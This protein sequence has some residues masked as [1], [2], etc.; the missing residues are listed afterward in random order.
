M[1]IRAIKMLVTLPFKAGLYTGLIA[2]GACAG[3]YGPWLWSTGMEAFAA[4]RTKADATFDPQVLVSPEKELDLI[5]K[6]RDRIAPD[7]ERAQCLRRQENAELDYLK[8]K[9]KLIEERVPRGDNETRS[10]GQILEDLANAIS[11]NSASAADR[12]LFEDLGGP[13]WALLRKRASALKAS[14]EELTA[15]NDRVLR[16][17]EQLDKKRQMTL[18]FVPE[19][20]KSQT[21]SPATDV[22]KPT[23]P[24]I[25]EM[26]TL[27]EQSHENLFK[28]LHALDAG[29]LDEASKEAPKLTS[30]P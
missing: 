28:G 22:G 20:C 2:I 10:A 17:Q 1:I 15:L 12:E 24:E 25:E 27:L 18:R 9:A 13:A 26:R 16:L 8:E 6:I 11:S 29:L 23:F 3:A 14:L 5:A 7:V 19:Q 4:L 30:S 21:R